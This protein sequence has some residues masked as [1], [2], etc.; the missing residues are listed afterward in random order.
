MTQFKN[1]LY[2]TDARP[3]RGSSWN[4]IAPQARHL[5]RSVT[6]RTRRR[7]YIRSAYFRKDKI[8]LSFF[9]RHLS[10]K[11]YPEQLRRMRYLPCA[12]ELIQRS[13]QHPTSKQNPNHAD[14]TLHRFAGI[15]PNQQLFMVQIKEYKPT[16]RKEL[17]S[18]FP[19]D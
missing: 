17:M 19:Y 5:L 4:E 7:S 15:T 14:E 10:Q 1:N 11:P 8:F 9:W 12:I 16:G 13:R 3:F 2:H 6:R 18:I